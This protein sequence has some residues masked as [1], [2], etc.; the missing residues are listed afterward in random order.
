MFHNPNSPKPGFGTIIVAEIHLASQVLDIQNQKLDM[1]MKVLDPLFQM[2]PST[3]RNIMFEEI[4][5][6]SKL[7]PF[8]LKK[9]SKCT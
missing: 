5:R 8:F 9:S 7:G 3:P 1:E 4:Y 2:L 6:L